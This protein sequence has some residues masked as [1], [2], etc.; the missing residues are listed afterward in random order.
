MQNLS[1]VA[2]AVAMALT[3]T[4]AWAQQAPVK[5]E[6]IEVTATPFGREDAELA[7]P[8]SVVRSEDLRRSRA[9]S[10][11]DTLSQQPGV[12][13]SAFGAGAGRPVIRGLDGPRIRILENGLGTLDVSTVSPDHMVVTES[14]HAEQIEILRGPASLL[15]GSGAIGGIV[16]VVSNLIPRAPAEG[17]SGDVEMRASS[18]NRERTAGANLDGGAGN[19]AWHVDG[20]ARKTRDY[21]TPVGRLADSAVDARG[22][23]AGGSYVTGRGYLGFGVS[24]LTN[25]YGLPT[26]EGSRIDL[27]QTRYE[28]SGELSNPFV[29]AERIRFRIGH[30][31]YEHDEIE[32]TGDVATTFKNKATEGRIELRHAAW[33][34]MKGTVGAQFQDQ[35]MSALGD[36]AVFP[37]TRSKGAGAFVVEQLERGAWTFDAGIRFERQERTPTVNAENIDKFGAAVARSFSLTTPA[38]GAVWKFDDDYRFAVSATQAQR[39]P[40]TEELYSN[41]PHGATATFDIGDPQLVKEVSRNVDV[42][43]RKVNGDLRWR[44]NAFWNRFRDYVHATSVDEDGDGVADRI[45]DFLVQRFVQGGAT[46]RGGEAELT[47]RPIEKPW[48]LRIFGDVVRAKLG[49]G[50]NVPRIA[51][52]RLGATL[53]G[54]HG[55]WSGYGTVI[56]AWAQNRVA[57]LESVTPSYT[58]VDAEIAYNLGRVGGM[59]AKVFLQGTNLLDEE[60]RLH[61]SY[62][63]DVAPLMGRS[64]TLGLRADF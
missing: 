27:R 7:Q 33:G 61:T 43:L 21:D 22:S 48:G 42:T 14:L 30:S 17:T 35:D 46:F 1:W 23:G 53:E 31:D 36:E 44:V 26:G 59:A 52:A 32:S 55:Q 40:S 25:V 47:Y 38:I 3:P 5:A 63:K 6:K 18:A 57:T 34:A 64:F 15:Y 24:G 19:W 56:H 13:S 45:D 50:T 29:G 62:L 4:F 28:S 10:I 12:Q 41:G 8:A 49:D 9:A 60:I 2:R 58:R 51:P 54:T 37:K 16:N 20:F 11:G 39:A